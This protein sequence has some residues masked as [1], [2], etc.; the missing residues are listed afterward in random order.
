[1]H[2]PLFIRHLGPVYLRPQ[3]RVEL[4]CRVPLARREV[5]R[6]RRP[7]RSAM[8]GSLVRAVG[9]FSAPDTEAGLLRQLL[10]LASGAV[11]AGRSLAR[12][13]SRPQTDS[14]PCPFD[15]AAAP[16]CRHRAHHQRPWCQHQL[17]RAAGRA[18]PVR[19]G[20]RW[21]RTSQPRSVAALALPAL[22]AAPAP[23]LRHFSNLHGDKWLIGRSQPGSS[24]HR[25]WEGL[26]RSVAMG[27]P[28]PATSEAPHSLLLCGPHATPYPGHKLVPCAMHGPAP[29]P[30]D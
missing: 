2:N 29:T 4:Q 25:K 17:H 20:S 21:T 9:R 10:D 12:R 8:R 13:I 16:W 26:R 23:S 27:R 1:M 15:L 14:P 28:H 22:A 11:S 18:V 24:D 3:R 5:L 30:R 7:I 19:P 6:R